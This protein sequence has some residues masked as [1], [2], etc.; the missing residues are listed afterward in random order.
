MSKCDLFGHEWCITSV[1]G[2]FQCHR[3][4]ETKTSKKPGRSSLPVYCNLLAHCPGC[5]GSVSRDVT[6]LFCALHQNIAIETFP[7]VSRPSAR[8]QQSSVEADQSS[9]W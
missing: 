3:L 8:M 4:L 1:P 7:V 5:L 9:L 6:I 2:W